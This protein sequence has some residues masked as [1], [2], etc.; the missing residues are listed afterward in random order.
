VTYAGTY[1]MTI[2]TKWYDDRSRCAREY[3]AHSKV[4]RYGKIRTVRRHLA[5]RVAP[6]FQQL[7]YRRFRKWI[8]KRQLRVSFEREEVA[9]E[10]ERDITIQ[11]RGMQYRGREWVASPFPPKVLSYA[12]KRRK[13]KSSEGKRAKG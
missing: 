10:A 1:R 4:S 2:A 6:Y 3:E 8:P 5:R 9:T 11:L 12:K 7:I 13:R